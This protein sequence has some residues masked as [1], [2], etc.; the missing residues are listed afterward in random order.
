MIL[1]QRP[2]SL[3]KLPV[4]SVLTEVSGLSPA[5]NAKSLLLSNCFNDLSKCF[6][7]EDYCMCYKPCVSMCYF[8][9]G[10]REIVSGS[11]ING[12]SGFANKCLNLFRFMIFYDVVHFQWLANVT[13]L[14]CKCACLVSCAHTNSMLVGKFGF[15][16]HFG[17]FNS[18]LFCFECL[19][20]W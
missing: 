18:A 12:P 2:T 16:S 4:L 19:M 11:L 17:T 5:L 13:C 20:F 8:D 9:N 7:F 6:L 15:L 3:L 14:T 1:A 10:R